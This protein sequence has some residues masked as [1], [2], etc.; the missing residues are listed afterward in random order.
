MRVDSSGKHAN[1]LNSMK[2]VCFMGQWYR[3]LIVKI[4]S[5]FELARKLSHIKLGF[6]WK[7]TIADIDTGGT[8]T[9]NIA[10]RTA[11]N[12]CPNLFKNVNSAESGSVKDVG[13]IDNDSCDGAEPE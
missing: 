2:T 1:V 8:Y 9:G 4:Q 7:I 5:I 11:F 10:V 13:I 3:R 12:V 6:S